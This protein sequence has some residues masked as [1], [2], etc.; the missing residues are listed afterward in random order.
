MTGALTVNT[1][2]D[3]DGGLGVRISSKITKMWGQ[4]KEYCVFMVT[5][6]R[7]LGKVGTDF[8]Q[9]KI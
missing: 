1:C 7:I 4:I 6:L 9:E 2:T 5:D 8:F 3:P